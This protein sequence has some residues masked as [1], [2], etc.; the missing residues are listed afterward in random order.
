MRIFTTTLA[1]TGAFLLSGCMT[2]PPANLGTTY[3]CDRGT[4]LQVSYLGEAALVRING[5]RAI[6]FRETPSNSGNV[7]ES[8]GN[9]LARNGNTVTWNTS[10]R[11]A[12]EIC[13]VVN[14]IQ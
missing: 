5:G 12:P 1:A 2:T 6:P 14:T 4:R 7:Y 11:S 8:A 13:R 10:A 9:R 3:E